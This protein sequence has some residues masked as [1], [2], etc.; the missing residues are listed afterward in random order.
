MGQDAQSTRVPTRNFRSDL[1]IAC[2]T[3]DDIMV[4]K[5]AMDAH[6]PANQA[7]RVERTSLCDARDRRQVLESAK[8]EGTGAMTKDYVSLCLS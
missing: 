8:A 5:A 6:G 3:A 4:L 2:N 7:D 1:S